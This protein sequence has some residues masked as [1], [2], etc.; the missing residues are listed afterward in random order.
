M[1]LADHTGTPI[2]QGQRLAILKAVYQLKL[3]YDVPIE[4]GHWV[5]PCVLSSL[6][7]PYT[8]RKTDL[9]YFVFVLSPNSRVYRPG[10][11]G[12]TCWCNTAGQNV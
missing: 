6:G 8:T 3:Q 9:M 10:H 7:I 5:P 1:K 2:S 11:G 12:L 4:E